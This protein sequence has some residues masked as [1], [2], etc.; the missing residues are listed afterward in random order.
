M[1]IFPSDVEWEPLNNENFLLFCAK[2]Y[3]GRFLASTEEFEDD[4]NR[5]KYIKKLLTRYIQSGELKER[6]ILNHIIVL[7][8]VFGPVVTT[9][10]LYLK[11]GDQFFYVKPFLKFLK[12]LPTKIYNVGDIESIDMVGIQSCPQITE[13]LRE[14]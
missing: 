4:L 3:D 14:L 12:I 6:L 9:R 13:V 8:N 5:I 1:N 7:N 2:H 10:I 11:L